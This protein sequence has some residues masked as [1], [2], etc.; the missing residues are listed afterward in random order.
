[1]ANQIRKINFGEILEN[2][3]INTYYS[4][5][6]NNKTHLLIHSSSKTDSEIL[7]NNL[8]YVHDVPNYLKTELSTISENIK[9]NKINSYRGS[10]IDLSNYNTIDDYLANE[11]TSKERYEI[12]RRQKRLDNCFKPVYKMYY[13]DISKSDYDIIFNDY[14]EMLLRRLEQKQ[15]Y[16]EEL[17]YWE[18]R[19]NASFKLINERKACVFVIYHNHTPIAIYINSIYDKIIFNEV[20]AYDI[21]FSR[22]NIGILIFIK[23]IEWSINHEFHIMDMSKGDFSYKE[24]FRNGTYTFENHIIYNS[25]NISISIKARLLILK[26][27]LLYKFLPLLKKIKLHKLNTFIKRIKNRHLFKEYTTK[28]NLNIETKKLSSINIMDHLELINPEDKVYSLLKKSIIDF[29][30]LNVEFIDDILVYRD[31]TN[32]KKFYIKGKKS[33][34]QIVI[35]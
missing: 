3:I 26:L 10:L 16:W 12:R 25:N 31:T 27:N 4:K 23:V 14:K 35:Q 34:H 15:S 1:M 22:F 33:I 5:L 13:G 17:D 8:I 6:Y 18:E 32:E 29:A 30:F 11:I 20:V 19:Y 24:R 2:D 28:T 7:K 21:D 9:L